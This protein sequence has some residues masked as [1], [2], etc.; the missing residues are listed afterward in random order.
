MSVFTWSGER[1]RGDGPTSKL[2]NIAVAPGVA[3]FFH[4]V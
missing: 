3:L 1:S 4:R 2:P